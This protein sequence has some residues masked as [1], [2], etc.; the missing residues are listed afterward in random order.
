MYFKIW[1]ECIFI[2]G[3]EAMKVKNDETKYRLVLSDGL[4]LNSYFYV[5]YH[6]GDL[7]VKKQVKY[8]TLLRLEEYT[9]MDGEN[10]TN[11]NARLKTKKKIKLFVCYCN[12]FYF[13]IDNIY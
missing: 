10:V 7:I 5:S 11:N 8:G 2:E 1:F 13:Q 12:Q 4:H 6:F 3:Y 9:F